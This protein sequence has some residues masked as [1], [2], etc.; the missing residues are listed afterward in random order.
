M[1]SVIVPESIIYMLMD[2]F[3]LNYC[4]AEFKMLNFHR[5]KPERIEFDI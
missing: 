4:E 2:F 1:Y 5:V 3:N